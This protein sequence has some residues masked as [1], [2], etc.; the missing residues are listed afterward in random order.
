MYMAY[1]ASLRSADLS[2]Q[3][4]A[5]ICKD[6]EIIAMG[7]N[8]VPKSGGGLYWMEI[9]PNTG[10]YSDKENGRDYMVG[11]DSNRAELIRISRD[12]LKRLGLISDTLEADSLEISDVADFLDLFKK[13]KLGELTEYGRMVHAEMESLMICAR[14]NQSCQDAEMYVTTFPCHNCAKHII[15]AG[16]KKIIYIEPYPKSKTLEFYQDSTTQDAENTQ[17]KVLFSPFFGVGPSRFKELFAMRL[18]PYPEK[19]R[20]DKTTGRKI[21]Y[22]RNGSS[23]RAQLLPVSYLDKEQYF[24]ALFEKYDTMLKKEVAEDAKQ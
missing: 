5:V 13:S 23:I 18:N 7:T 6:Q 17:G 22:N 10:L 15:A 16:V 8:D 2:R 12:I 3:V 9:D 1:S 14:S 4:G 21:N 20:K 24:L 19:E 11:Y